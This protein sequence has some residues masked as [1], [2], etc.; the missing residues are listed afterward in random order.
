MNYTHPVPDELSRF[1]GIGGGENYDPNSYSQPNWPTGEPVTREDAT[2]VVT[3]AAG[4]K[5]AVMTATDDAVVWVPGDTDIDI[6]GL[7]NIV[8][9]NRITIASDRGA[10]GPGA[11]LY[12]SESPIP[13]L[14]VLAANVRIT[15]LR[16]LAPI[17]EYQDYEWSKEGVCITINAD[18]VEVDNCVFRGFGYAG[19]EVGR[20]TLVDDVHVHHNRFV[21]NLL[22]ELGYGVIVRSARVLILGNYFDDNRHAVASDG[23]RNARYIARYNFC[24]PHTVLH[25][26]DMHAADEVDSDAGDFA[27]RWFRIVNNVVMAD[28]ELRGHDATGVYI[29]GDPL[30]ESLIAHNQFAHHWTDD[31]PGWG[32]NEWGD[33]YVLD[34]ESVD[35]SNI[36]V[37]NNYYGVTSP[38]P[39][40]DF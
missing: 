35:D 1:P 10:G 15:G 26:F 23:E 18:A 6:T 36:T 28:T 21:D 40:P 27:G 14:N 4:F 11:L 37:G 19:V 13:L 31:D 16:F 9:D 30:E 8:V 17:T 3:T 7:E 20:R 32:V 22:A 24:G 34:V 2:A 33:A 5:R 25:T 39:I 29:R 12:T 38:E